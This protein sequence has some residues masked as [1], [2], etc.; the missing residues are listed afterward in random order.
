MLVHEIAKKSAK[1][2]YFLTLLKRSRF[3]PNE[4][5]LFFVTCIR[6]LIDYACSDSSRTIP[7]QKSLSRFNHCN[8]SRVITYNNRRHGIRSL[9]FC[10]FRPVTTLSPFNPVKF[11]NYAGQGLTAVHYLK[12]ICSFLSFK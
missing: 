8:Q 5:I 9:V 4:L 3:P 6:S 7:S 11:F 1:M 2:L 10:I 12:L